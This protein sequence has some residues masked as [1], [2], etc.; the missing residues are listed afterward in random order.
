M[1]RMTLSLGA[2]A[3]A[4]LPLAASAET[5]APAAARSISAPVAT[6]DGTAL[7]TVTV[8]DSA[9]G[10][11]LV[12]LDLKGVPE[13]VHAV[14]IHETGKCDAPDFKSA[15]GHLAGDK[16]HG[17]HHADGMHPGDLPNVTAGADSIVKAEFF[18]NYATM[19]QIMDADGAAFIMHV[20]Q[21]DYTS[22]P[23]GD[24]GGRLACGV[25]Q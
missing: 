7:G 12:T 23:A 10:T 9:S 11:L 24:A 5:A 16:A 17:I 6:A 15:G 18:N 1:T 21:D 19:D 4:A 20:G 14:H 25:F 13:G 22:Q 8:S 2:L 3:L